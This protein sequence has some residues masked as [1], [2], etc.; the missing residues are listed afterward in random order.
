MKF[1]EK[2]FGKA[3]MAL[4]FLSVWVALL[5][6]GTLKLDVLTGTYLSFELPLADAQG[7]QAALDRLA[8]VGEHH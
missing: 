1:L 7:W 2:H 6:A 4:V 5:L 3:W 8:R